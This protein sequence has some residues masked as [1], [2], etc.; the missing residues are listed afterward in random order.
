[1]ASQTTQ[2]VA[3]KC[4]T[5]ELSYTNCAIINASNIDPQRVK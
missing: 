4:P 3:M 5:D 2:L 1:M